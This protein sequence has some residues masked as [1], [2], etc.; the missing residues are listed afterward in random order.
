M[1]T[2]YTTYARAQKGA[3]IF[4]RSTALDQAQRA[5]DIAS[6]REALIAQLETN[7]DFARRTTILDDDQILAAITIVKAR[8]AARG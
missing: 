7:C 1:K 6:A 4:T 5:D 3:P 2:N 8:I